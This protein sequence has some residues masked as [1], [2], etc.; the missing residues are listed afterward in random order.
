MEKIEPSLSS[1]TIQKLFDGFKVYNKYMQFS[2]IK[3][4]IFLFIL[5]FKFLQKNY[6]KGL[7]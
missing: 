2:F 7:K 1:N 3:S 4:L 5:S 6:S